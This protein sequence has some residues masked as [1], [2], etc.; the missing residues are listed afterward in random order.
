LGAEQHHVFDLIEDYLYLVPVLKAPK[1]GFPFRLY[2]AAEDKVIE[3][4]LT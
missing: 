1:S 3:V 2:V 4:V